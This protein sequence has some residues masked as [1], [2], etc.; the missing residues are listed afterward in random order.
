MWKRALTM[1]FFVQEILWL[2][3]LEQEYHSDDDISA[4]SDSDSDILET[5]EKADFVEFLDNDTY[6]CYCA[7]TT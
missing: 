1:E 2:N 6:T 5:V 3:I 4:I 7:G